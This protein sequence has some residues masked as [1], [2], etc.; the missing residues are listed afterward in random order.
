[1]TKHF[2]IP[3]YSP[4]HLQFKIFT[5][6][7]IFLIFFSRNKNQPK[8]WQSKNLTGQC[9]KISTICIFVNKFQVA[10]FVVE[11][12]VLEDNFLITFPLSA[13]FRA[14]SFVSF[15]FTSI[16]QQFSSNFTIQHSLRAVIKQIAINAIDHKLP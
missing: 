8:K 9:R 16:N 10:V 11:S 6:A 13:S 12:S 1:M 3:N 15:T 14:P 4:T 5:I 2:T 7:Y